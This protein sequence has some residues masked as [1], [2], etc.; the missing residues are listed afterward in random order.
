VPLQDFLY[1][2]DD[3]NKVV[4]RSVKWGQ[5]HDGLTVVKEGLN[6][7]DRVIIGWTE[8]PR[9]GDIVR[10]KLVSMPGSQSE[11]ATPK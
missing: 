5:E 7:G 3:Q 2:V 8:V 9:P 10:A 6:P 11:P 1:L 4:R